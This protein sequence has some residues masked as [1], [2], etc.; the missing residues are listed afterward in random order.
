MRKLGSMVGVRYL[1]SAVRNGFSTTSSPQ[2]TVVGKFGRDT[3]SRGF[4][5]ITVG[6]T[7]EGGM[8]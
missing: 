6:D 1:E 3:V 2:A 8:V 4:G 5:R 7:V